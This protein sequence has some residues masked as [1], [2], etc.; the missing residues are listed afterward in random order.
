MIDHLEA[1]REYNAWRRGGGD[2]A[3]Y[4]GIQKTLGVTIDKAIAEL[5]MLRRG[6]CI[7]TRCGI[8]Q[9][10]EHPKGDF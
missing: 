4:D 1:L 2:S 5:E 6:E 7:C 3:K 10:G 9:D 8:R